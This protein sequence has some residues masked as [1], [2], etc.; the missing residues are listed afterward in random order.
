MNQLMKSLRGTTK[1]FS[2]R[3]ARLLAK[4]LAAMQD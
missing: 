1:T 4:V 3:L 2:V